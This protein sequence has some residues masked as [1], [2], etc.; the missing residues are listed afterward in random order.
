[1]S[2][3]TASSGG[4]PLFFMLKLLPPRPDFAFSLSPEEAALMGR[5]VVYWRELLTT[6]RAIIC[7]PV[8]D[9]AGPWG[10]GILRVADAAEMTA[11]TGADPVILAAC[12]FRYETLP[13]LQA[14]TR[15]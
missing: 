13:M 5:H 1:M 2:G 9:P 6:G 14:M 8:A 11:L 4:A 15:P 7:G 10:L 12:G 3:D